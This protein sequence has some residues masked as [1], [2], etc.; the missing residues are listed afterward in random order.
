ML[1]LF[2]LHFIFVVFSIIM[3]RYIEKTVIVLN[4]EGRQM[5]N[6]TTVGVSVVSEIRTNAHL[7]WLFLT[8]YE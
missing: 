2:Y 8:K 7:L 4:T 5:V 6:K 3:M 1:N